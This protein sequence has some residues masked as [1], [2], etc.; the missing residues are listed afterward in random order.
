MTEPGNP[1]AAPRA[2][3]V[4]VPPETSPDGPLRLRSE[5]LVVPAGAGQEWL[6]ESWRVFRKAPGTLIAMVLLYILIGFAMG[7]LPGVGDLFMSLTFGIWSAGWVLASDRL[8]RG[9]ELSVAS[10]FAGFRHPRTGRLF[11]IGLVYLGMMLAVF[12]ATLAIAVAL[13]GVSSLDALAGLDPASLVLP[14]VLIIFLLV[15]GLFL[16]FAWVGYAPVLV[17]MH[18]IE[19]L[20]A[21]RLSMRAILGNWRAMTVYGLL[22][23][24][25]GIASVFTLFIGMLVLLPMV[26]IVSY[27]S[28][29][30]IFLVGEVS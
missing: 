29:R 27:L 24:G 18:D 22:L 12:A 3:I 4:A 10:L 30:Q 26:F 13:L 19:V 6:G 8:Y 15:T 25:L 14:L 7:M 28:Y 2:K 21:C 1:Y 11:V 17:S 5:P 20:P 16:V 23:T 9:E